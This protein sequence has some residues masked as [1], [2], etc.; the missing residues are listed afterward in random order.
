MQGGSRMASLRTGPLPSTHQD[1]KFCLDS[2]KPTF[3]NLRSYKF[4]MQKRCGSLCLETAVW[5]LT[6]GYWSIPINTIFSGMNIHLPAILMFTRGTRF[7]HTAKWCSIFFSTQ[8]TTPRRDQ[9]FGLPRSQTLQG[10]VQKWG[11]HGKNGMFGSMIIPWIDTC[12]MGIF[13][14]DRKG[15]KSGYF[16]GIMESPMMN[17][18]AVWTMFYMFNHIWDVTGLFR[19]TLKK[20]NIYPKLQIVLNLTGPGVYDIVWCVV[21][22]ASARI[23]FQKV[24]FI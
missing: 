24:W 9:F 21:A 1:S 3:T 23:V 12:I 4:R 14:G 10:P 7:W 19:D 5:I 2:L 17:W 11:C 16:L 15:I 6:N 20:T 18:L 22:I 8:P 13:F